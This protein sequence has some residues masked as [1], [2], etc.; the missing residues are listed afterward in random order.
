MGDGFVLTESNTD[1]TN[2]NEMTMQN[3]GKCVLI[4]ALQS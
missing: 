2:F 3:C 1:N 4:L